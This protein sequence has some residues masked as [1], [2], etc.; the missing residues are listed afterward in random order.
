LVVWTKRSRS[1]PEKNGKTR[2]LI[3]LLICIHMIEHLD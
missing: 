2:I 1:M 3:A